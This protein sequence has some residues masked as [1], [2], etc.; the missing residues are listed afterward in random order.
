MVLLRLF[1]VV[2]ADV[3]QSV[4]FGTLCSTAFLFDSFP[5]TPQHYQPPGFKEAEGDT[6]E[7]ESEPVKL[8]MGEVVTPF[9]TLKL[10]MTTERQRLEQVMRMKHEHVG[11]NLLIFGSF[12]LSL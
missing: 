11:V 10:D 7:F 12:K 8:T 9:H 1:V 3:S 4:D 5:V 2:V 6:M